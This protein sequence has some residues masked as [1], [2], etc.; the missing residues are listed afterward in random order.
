MPGVFF[1]IHLQSM[2]LFLQCFDAVGWVQKNLTPAALK[3]SF[4]EVLWGPDLTRSDLHTNRPSK[5]KVK[6]VV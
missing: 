2:L 1:S 5:Q 6:V 3:G 4:L